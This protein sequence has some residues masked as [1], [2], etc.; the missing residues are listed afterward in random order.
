MVA[1]AALSLWASRVVTR[2]V[3]LSAEE[4]LELVAAGW[5]IASDY[6]QR[7]RDPASGSE[8]TPTAALRCARGDR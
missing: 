8:R 5:T 2:T 1:A 6:P 4:E 3:L 7:W